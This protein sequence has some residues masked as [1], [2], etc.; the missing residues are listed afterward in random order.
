MLLGVN[1]NDNICY[2]LYGLQAREPYISSYT[3]HNDSV[4]WVDG[5]RKHFWGSYCIFSLVVDDGR[6]PPLPSN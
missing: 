5:L 1:R 4:P 6:Q 2:I 3:I